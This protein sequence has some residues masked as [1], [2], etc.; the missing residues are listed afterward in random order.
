MTIRTVTLILFLLVS[1]LASAANFRFT[2]VA[3]PGNVQHNG[4]NLNAQQEALLN[5]WLWANYAPTD[6]VDGSPTFGQVLPRNTANEAEAYKRWAYATW[7]G[8]RAQ[9]RKWKREQDQA[10]ITEP[11]VPE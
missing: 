7:K 11:T 8:T 1:S 6:T 2:Y 5:D 4:P 10:L 3:T 9:I